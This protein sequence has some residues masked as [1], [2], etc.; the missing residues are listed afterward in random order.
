MA[1]DH[2]PL[3]AAEMEPIAKWFRDTLHNADRARGV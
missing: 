1:I 3:A 2:N